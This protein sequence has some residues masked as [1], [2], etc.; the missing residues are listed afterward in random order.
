MTFHGSF[1]ALLQVVVAAVNARSDVGRAFAYLGLSDDSVAVVALLALVALPAIA[2]RVTGLLLTLADARDTV[3][4]ARARARFIARIATVPGVLAIVPIIAFRVPRELVE[5]VL[6]P[7]VVTLTGMAWIQ[8]WSW[9]GGAIPPRGG[10][11]A[12]TV[13]YPLGAVLMRLAIFHVVLRPGIRFY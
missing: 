10:A 13:A 3:A 7:M 12:L 6:P 5:V 8:A 11:G 2:H 1:Q 4:D 9:R